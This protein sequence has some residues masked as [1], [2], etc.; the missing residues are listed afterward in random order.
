MNKSN[1]A[2]LNKKNLRWSDKAFT[3]QVRV[4]N[5]NRKKQTRYVVTGTDKTLYINLPSVR[6]N[7]VL[8]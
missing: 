6:L 5:G 3:S 7:V 1:E 4:F 2:N 8:D